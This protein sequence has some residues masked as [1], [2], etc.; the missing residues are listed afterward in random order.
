MSHSTR[1][2]S[3]LVRGMLASVLGAGLVAGGTATGAHAAPPVSE[4]LGAHV[5][6]TGEAPTGYSVTFRYDA[7]DD[8]QSVQ[9]YGEWLFSKPSSIVSTTTADL[10]WG[11]EWLPA[12]V[13]Q[14]TPGRGARPR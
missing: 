4:D 11:S 8:V 7:P 6:K 9:I 2:G 1:K 13:P 10:R 12:D 3:R 14:A 5:V